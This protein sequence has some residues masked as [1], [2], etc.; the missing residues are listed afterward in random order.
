MLSGLI[1]DLYCIRLS[2]AAPICV[3]YTKLYFD[4]KHLQKGLNRRGGVKFLGPFFKKVPSL[5][6][7]ERCPKF[8]EYALVVVTLTR[9]TSRVEKTKCSCLCLKCSCRWC[10]SYYNHIEHFCLKLQNFLEK[11]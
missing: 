6:I 5:T 8:L 4:K 3:N 11:N 1:L 9:K 10:Y 7:I 2:N